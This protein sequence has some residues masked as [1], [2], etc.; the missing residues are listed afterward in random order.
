[1]ETITQLVTIFTLPLALWGLYLNSRD[2]KNARTLE[3]AIAFSDAFRSRWESEWRQALK[4][5][6][7]CRAA[8]QKIPAELDDRLLNLLNWLDWV[9]YLVQ[10][11]AL[12]KPEP[13]LHSIAP[14][15][16]RAVRVLAPILERGEQQHGTEYW[17]G[18]RAL[19]SL[20]AAT[21]GQT[22]PIVRPRRGSPFRRGGL[23]RWTEMRRPASG[24]SP[25]RS[26]N[27]P[28]QPR[29]PAPGRGR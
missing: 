19:E 18:V 15:I 14:Q 23:F 27:S 20:L 16:L 25:G 1:M 9:G 6:E 24:V 7:A 12:A 29:D 10:S 28:G 21:R 11:K 13:I 4:E 5:A 22:L 26:G 3:A 2:A 8:N 17:S